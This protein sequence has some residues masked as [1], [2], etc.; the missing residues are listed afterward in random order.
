MINKSAIEALLPWSEPRVISNARGTSSVRTADPNGS[1]WQLWR[2]NK[3]ELQALKVFPKLLAEENKW[4]VN[5][6]GEAASPVPPKSEKG[7]R[8]W[9]A[10]QEAIFGWFRDGK[11]ALVVKARAGTGKTTTIKQAFTFAPE[12]RM[13]YAVFNKKNQ[14]E[15][16]SAITDPRVEIKTLHSV[17]FSFIQQIWPG[18]RPADE[19]EQERIEA[20]IGDQ[21]PKAVYGQI[22]KL[23]SFAKNT[24]VT[25]G[26][27][28]LVEL[29]EERD[30][31]CLGLEA[32]E[33]GGWTRL[34]LAGVVLKVLELSKQQDK[35]GRI[36]FNDMVW[37]PVAMGWVRATYELVVIDEAQDMNLPQLLMAK[38]ACKKGGRVCVVGDDR[39][40]IYHFRGAASGGMQMMKESLSALELGLTTTYRCPKAVVALAAAIVPDYKAADSAP[41][42]LITNINMMGLEIELKVGDAVLSRSNAPLMPVCLSLLRKGVPARI[43]GRDLGKALV[44]IVEKLNARSIPQ[45][46]TR[47]ETWRD[48]QIARHSQSKNFEEKAVQINDQADTLR[49]IAEGV[50]SVREIVNRILAVFQDSGADSKP[51]VVLSTVHKAKGLEWNKVFILSDTFNRKQPANAAPVS[52]SVAEQRAMEES[53][54]YYVALTRAKEQLVMV[55]K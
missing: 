47:I 27:D 54:V 28:D 36:S 32:P 18:A 26:V 8:V 5:W 24:L 33:N 30:V 51:S 31:E 53:N 13:L 10:E 43:E 22:R 45:F 14:V 21:A 39:Q 42:G 55:S 1:F 20:V 41:E 11:G 52:P 25:P 2:S 4:V 44:E 23:V 6:Y 9:S 29:A 7:K 15:A 50:S 19:V 37:L 16:S 3:A 17:G 34:A 12:D 40:A 35:L 46:L 49:A 38:G 48:K